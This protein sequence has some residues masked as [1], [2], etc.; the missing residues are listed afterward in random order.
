ML[1]MQ[2]QFIFDLI[3][4]YEH[5]VNTF[6]MMQIVVC[7][8]KRGRI[9]QIMVKDARIAR[10][11]ISLSPLLQLF[12]PFSHLQLFLC[13]MQVKFIL[14]FTLLILK[15]IRSNQTGSVKTSKYQIQPMSMKRFFLQIVLSISDECQNKITDHWRFCVLACQ[16]FELIFFW[17]KHME[18]KIKYQLTYW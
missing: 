6:C 11:K 10:V 12:H 8:F 18:F 1:C 4:P 13:G 3:S 16:K 14:T 7:P 5:I 2:M 9:T 17:K 15:F